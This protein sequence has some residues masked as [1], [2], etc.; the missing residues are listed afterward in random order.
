[1]P[2]MRNEMPTC[3]CVRST[4]GGSAEWVRRALSKGEAYERVSNGELLRQR[5]WLTPNPGLLR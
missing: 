3:A 1:M 2:T 5:A 4:M